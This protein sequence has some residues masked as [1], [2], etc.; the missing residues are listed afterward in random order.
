[1]A[2]LVRT[3]LLTIAWLAAVWCLLLL[4]A[5]VFFVGPWLR[6]YAVNVVPNHGPWL[7]ITCLGALGVAL[8]AHMRRQTGMTRALLAAAALATLL[9]GSVIGRFLYVAHANGARIELSRTL[10]WRNYGDR[11]APDES[12][13]YAR[14]D[15]QPL[16]LDIYHGVRPR[17]DAL[18]PILFVVH[19]GG[20]SVGSR[21]LGAANMR[22]QA[23]HGWTVISIDYRL[24]RP[25]R[26]TWN[27]APRDV[28]CALAWTA[29]N[30][31]A[32]HLDLSR[33]VVTGASA[34][35]SLAMAAAYA[36]PDQRID[37]VCGPHVPKAAAVIAR[38]PLIDAAAS[39]SHPSEL[40]DIQK[41]ILTR[42]LGGSPQ[43]YPDRYA[44]VNLMRFIRPN[45]PPTLIL[46]GDSDSVVPPAGAIAF[47]ESATAKGADVRQILFPYSGHEFN[48]TYGSIPNQAI[49][50]IVTA[51]TTAHGLNAPEAIV[52]PSRSASAGGR[53]SLSSNDVADPVP[54]RRVRQRIL[55]EA[56]S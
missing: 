8:T 37:P 25:G 33:L 18:S 17:P 39:W 48:T 50:Q 55:L 36:T 45:L 28:E 6:I 46:G 21:T 54:A 16:W 31:A 27:L 2:Q 43:Q 51:F 23:A 13:I 26:P 29:A 10:S 56:R 35:G 49:L 15:G 42:Y 20:F 22:W 4:C 44:A 32:L 40:N 3:G 9:A 11:A 53:T 5:A 14:P 41:A 7:L 1:M 24:A 52:R 19:G 12:R 38:V 34:G 30:A 47:T